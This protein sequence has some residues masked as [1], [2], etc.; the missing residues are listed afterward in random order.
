M[1]MFKGFLKEIHWKKIAIVVI[2]LIFIYFL[3]YF[4]MLPTRS[5]PIEGL[6]NNGDK[7][8][9]LILF[10][11]DWCPHCKTA[12]PAWDQVKSEYNGTTKNGYTI[13]FTDINCTADDNPE[14]D[15]MMNQYKIEGFPTIKMLKDGQVI[16]FDAKP[17]QDSLTKF[18]NTAI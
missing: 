6:E 10:Y 2:L 12:K 14:S 1:N 4:F 9:E 11:V 16:E 13:V 3:Y 5:R 7:S 8:V 15:R 18:L 17:T